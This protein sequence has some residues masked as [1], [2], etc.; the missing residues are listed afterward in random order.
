MMTI[1]NWGIKQSMLTCYTMRILKGNGK[2]KQN[3]FFGTF[4][5]LDLY[6]FILYFTIIL[7]LFVFVSE[8]V[9]ML[10][11]ILAN[12]SDD[13]FF[14]IVYLR[15]KNEFVQNPVENIILTGPGQY[16]KI[17][18]GSLTKTNRDNII[19]KYNIKK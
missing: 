7:S 9:V 18:T 13:M 3:I 1:V 15:Q 10:Y 11:S 2:K 17:L 16:T 14:V 8:P 4:V 5:S 6:F 19:V 12:L